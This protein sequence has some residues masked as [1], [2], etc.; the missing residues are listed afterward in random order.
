MESAYT[1]SEEPTVPPTPAEY[2]ENENVDRAI[3]RERIISGFDASVSTSHSILPHRSSLPPP[4]PALSRI[5]WLNTAIL[6]VYS[7]EEDSIMHN[8]PSRSPSRIM[9]LRRFQAVVLGTEHRL[10]RGRVRY[11]PGASISP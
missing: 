6:V 10:V 11:L 7:S 9:R 2:D 8:H 5:A 1:T 3:Q 4:S